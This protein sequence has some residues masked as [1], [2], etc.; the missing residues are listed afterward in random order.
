[1]NLTRRLDPIAIMI[2]AP[3]V[4]PFFARKKTVEAIGGSLGRTLTFALKIVDIKQY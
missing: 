1:M 3:R 2:Q 4:P